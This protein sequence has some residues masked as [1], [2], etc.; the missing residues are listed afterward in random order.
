MSDQVRVRFAPSPTGYL[1]VGGART[2]LFNWLLAR[3]TG[4]SFI[5]RIEDT[6]LARSTEASVQAIFDGMTWLGLDW[7]EGPGK[8]GPHA[9]YFQTQR[10]DTYREYTEKL[11]ALGRAYRDYLTA[12]ER[13]ALR[14]EAAAR[15]EQPRFKREWA[16]LTEEKR[17]AYEAEGRP[18]A[19]RFKAPDTGTI[20]VEDLVHGTVT[21]DAAQMVDDF[22][23][24]KAD[25][26]PTYNFA[27]VIDDATMGITH[28][29]RGDDH[30]SNTPKQIA[31][32]EALGLPVPRFGHIPMILGPD[33][34]RLS[35]RHGATSVMQY[36]EEGYLPQ[37]MVNYLVR[38]GWSHGD[39]EI[40]T[41]QE[42]IDL[43][44]V[45]G[46][47]KTAAVFDNQK[48]EWLNA[49]YMMEMAPAELAELMKPYWEKAGLS[50]AGRDASWLA[51]L[52]VS[53]QKRAKTLVQLAEQS[54]FAFPVELVYDE[55]AVAKFLTNENKPVLE[56]LRDRLRALES[57]DEAAMEEVFKGLAAERGLKL[58]AVIQPT[59]VAMTGSTA[60][61]GMYEV[62]ALMGRD[63]AMQRFDRAL[64]LVAA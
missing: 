31:I 42:M 25:G 54:R 18:F 44:E 16:E 3:H 43:F 51:A 53:L 6:D 9:P 24:V 20:V 4:G 28:V 30:L 58:G 39:Q 13:E 52:V 8:E 61:P 19:I 40:F 60:S 63:L 21:F 15:G 37:A 38:L 22:V 59:R 45:D 41:L 10:L 5:L 64:G 57:W 34:A 7:D 49:H 47:N 32:Y 1:H 27:V 29:L 56:T 55:A 46:I 50:V 12:E 17:A 36:A 35:K 2:A 11:F 48:L 23:I 14:N 33:K 26:V 62:L